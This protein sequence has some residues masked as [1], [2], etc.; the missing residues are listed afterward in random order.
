ML[1]YTACVICIGFRDAV[2]VQC[3]VLHC[4]A[5]RHTAHSK[6]KATSKEATS[7][8]SEPRRRQPRRLEANSP[9]ECNQRCVIA[10]GWP[11]ILGLRFR[12]QVWPRRPSP[13][14]SKIYPTSIVNG[15][16]P[17]RCACNGPS[18]PAWLLPHLG[19][20]CDV[21]KASQ[22]SVPV[23]KSAKAQTKPMPQEMARLPAPGTALHAW[24][25]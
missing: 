25:S 3:S 23:G 15:S 21:S 22:T 17:V 8:Q 1:C 18:R 2:C 4:P 5:V 19:C 14:R 16:D 9:P 12:D 7:K 10:L 13:A 24:S 20:S 6:K 11:K